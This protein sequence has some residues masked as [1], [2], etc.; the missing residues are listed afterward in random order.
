MA[1][2]KDE[3]QPHNAHE[4]GASDVFNFKAKIKKKKVPII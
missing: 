4:N 2:I 1:L 3:H